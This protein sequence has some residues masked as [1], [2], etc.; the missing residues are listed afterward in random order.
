MLS[1]YVLA[2]LGLIA[3]AAV[4][5]LKVTNRGGWIYR[6]RDTASGRLLTPN[7]TFLLSLFSLLYFSLAIP[8]VHFIMDAYVYRQDSIRYQ[9]LQGVLWLAIASVSLLWDWL[10][11]MLLTG[12]CR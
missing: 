12:F 2:S 4:V 1:N 9:R 6:T 8:S 7:T 11:V 10:Q 3:S 5:A